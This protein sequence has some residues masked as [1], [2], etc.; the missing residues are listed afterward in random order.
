VAVARARWVRARDDAELVTPTELVVSVVPAY[1]VPFPAAARAAAYMS[2]TA[3][4]STGGPFT[5]TSELRGHSRT[6]GRP[7]SPTRSGIVPVVRIGFSGRVSASTGDSRQPLPS[8]TSTVSNVYNPAEF[9][10]G[11]R[12]NS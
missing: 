4:A 12:R 2:T 8:G 1:S 5:P 9:Q 3:I 7:R 10:S 6:C 11:A